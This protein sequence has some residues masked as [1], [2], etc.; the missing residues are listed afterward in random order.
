M[1]KGTLSILAMVRSLGLTYLRR[2]MELSETQQVLME[3]VG[4][5]SIGIA[6]A[7]FVIICYEQFFG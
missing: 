6:V 3:R 2:H 1:A 7:L 5:A 4:L